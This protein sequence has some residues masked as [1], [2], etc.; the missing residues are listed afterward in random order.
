MKVKLVKIDTI[1]KD[2]FIH[3]TLFLQV[4]STKHFLWNW[5]VAYSYI[6]PT[7]TICGPTATT[8]QS[9]GRDMSGGIEKQ[10]DPIFTS[11]IEK[12]NGELLHREDS[13]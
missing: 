5:K 3:R 10:P 8:M 2:G 11:A 7:S 1:E 9:K 12:M 13:V 6:P 4:G